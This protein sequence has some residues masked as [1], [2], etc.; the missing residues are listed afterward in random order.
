MQDWRAA[1]DAFGATADD[2]C[3]AAAAEDDFG[4]VTS[5]FGAA[6]DASGVTAHGLVLQ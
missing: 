5:D 1:A 4:A 6:A 2:W 3:A